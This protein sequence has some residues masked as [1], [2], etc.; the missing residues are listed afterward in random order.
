VADE[1][2]DTDYAQVKI[3]SGKRIWKCWK[4]IK[5]ETLKTGW[6]LVTWTAK[7]SFGAFLGAL[8]TVGPPS[9]V[10]EFLQ[11]PISS[12]GKLFGKQ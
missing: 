11:N 2:V 6:G 8:V 5:I 4:I 1:P 12:L 3:I 10:I 9:W 7:T